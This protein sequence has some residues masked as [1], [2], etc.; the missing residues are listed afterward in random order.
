MS[1]IAAGRKNAS[2]TPMATWIRARCH[3]CATPAISSAAVSI[4]RTKR[5]TSA[6]SMTRCRCSLS[7]HTP[8]ISTNTASGTRLAASTMPM[9]VADPPISS[10][11]NGRATTVNITPTTEVA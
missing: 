2:H 5:R 4:C 1:P 6:A 9:S 8:P 11:A 7:A 10:T 3:T